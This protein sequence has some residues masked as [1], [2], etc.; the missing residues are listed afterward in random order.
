M[1]MRWGVAHAIILISTGACI[2]SI[3]AAPFDDPNSQANAAE[4]Y[5]SALHFDLTVD[6]SR[7]VLT[8]AVDIWLSRVTPLCSE[9]GR[10][11]G[12][13]SS[14]VVVLDTQD[15]NIRSV[16][17]ISPDAEQL[18]FSVG[19]KLPVLGSG[20]SITLSG[21]CLSPTWSATPDSADVG[22]PRAAGAFGLRIAYETT[23]NATSAGLQWLSVAQ[24]KD[25]KGP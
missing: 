16:S 24:T 21:T 22:R 17:C 18:Q 6:F 19:P 25:K 8:G 7:Q 15:L 13:C 14:S 11:H 10:G 20:L 12:A 23:A 4:F 1:P 2:H 3:A 5:T 9:V